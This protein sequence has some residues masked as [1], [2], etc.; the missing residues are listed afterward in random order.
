MRNSQVKHFRFAHSSKE[1]TWILDTGASDHIVCNP[2]LLTSLK[3]VHN[4][5]VKL[6]NGTYTHITHIGTLSFSPHFILHNVFCVP[7][8]YLNLISMSK[9]AFD[10]FYITIFLRQ[11]CV[12]QDLRSRKM[13]GMGTEKEGLY[14]LN[15]STKGTCNA[16]HTNT[17]NLWHQHLGHPSNKASSLFPFLANKTCISSTCSICP[18]AKLTRQPFPL[19]TTRSEFCF[20]LIHIDIW[21]GYHV[22]SSSSGAQYF[23]TIVD[24][25]SQSTWIYLIKTQI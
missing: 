20:D 3:L 7:L 16:V 25:H 17:N 6:S 8:F 1:T 18:L 10:S 22:P 19:S 13:I 5:W 23:L 15:Y 24:D 21:G 11:I 2:N 9:L 4:R 14:C 12:I